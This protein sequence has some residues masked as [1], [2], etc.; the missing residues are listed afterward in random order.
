MKATIKITAGYWSHNW[1]LVCSTPKTTRSFF[2][3][4][5][6]KVCSRLLGIRPYELVELI[7][8]NQIDSTV[9]KPRIA[10]LIVKE[11][12]LNGHSMKKLND[13]DLAVE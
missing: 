5:D 13:W 10:K 6:V 2:L 3:G 9:A 7:G 12:G 8:T 1:T 11:I 4:Q